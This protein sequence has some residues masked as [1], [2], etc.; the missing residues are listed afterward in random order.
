MKNDAEKRRYLIGFSTFDTAQRVTDVLIIGS[1]ASGLRA[2]LEAAKWGKVTVVTKEGAPE[3]A[4][5]LAQGGIAAAVSKGDS[6]QLH[7][8]DTIN[9]GQGLCNLK[10]VDIVVKEGV[11]RTKELA[12]LG[13]RF[14]TCDGKYA[15]AQEGGHSRP[16]ILRANG[17]ST[18]REVERVLLDRVRENPNIRILEQTFAIDLITHSNSCLG[19]LIQNPQNATEVIWAKQTILATG[20]AGQIYRETTNPE[21]ATGDGIALAYRAGAKLQDLEFIQFHPT[22]LYIAGAIR[23]LISETVRGEGAY[24]RTRDGTR[25]MLKYHKDAELAPRDVVS[26]AIVQELRR[27][28]DTSV[29]LDL[30]HLDCKKMRVRFPT[31]TALLF[32]FDLDIAKDLIPVRPSAH[33]IIGGVRT[34]SWGRTSIRNL[35]ACGET[36]CTG[37]HGANRLASNSLLEALVMGER[38]GE[39]AGR[40]LKTTAPSAPKRL[41]V[42]PRPRHDRILIRDVEDSLRSL[43]W[44]AVGVERKERTLREAKTLLDFWC[45]YVLAQEFANR[46]GWRLQNML[47]VGRL[48]TACALWRTESRGV[49]HR[50]DFP[51]MDKKWKKHTIVSR[52]TLQEE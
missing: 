1:G 51:Q 16:R 52:I 8:K 7:K 19:A 12:D 4:T 21:T 22:T 30:N 42:E 3:G 32:S 14:D 27:T 31:L 2:A 24:L 6:I 9:T 13:A 39:C 47:Q 18:G 26:L 33:Y 11:E 35:L 45:K 10:M 49:H 40:N 5:A 28:G 38:S 44:R 50:T 37:L 34:D 29:F 25:F 43:M 17:D 48:V 20:G 41:E 46:Q 23:A 36:A 15:F